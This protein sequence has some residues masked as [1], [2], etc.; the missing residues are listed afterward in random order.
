VEPLSGGRLSLMEAEA[1]VVRGTNHYTVLVGS[2][3]LVARGV[4]SFLAR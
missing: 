4:A 3:P 1:I 2:D